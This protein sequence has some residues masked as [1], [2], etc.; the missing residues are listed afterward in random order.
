MELADLARLQRSFDQR[1][2][3]TFDWSGPVT[4]DD[5][6]PLMHNVLSLCGE[7]GEVANLLKK[8]DRG[9][10]SFEELMAELPS[11]LA[12]VAIYI[13]KI[14]YQSNIDLEKAI[15][16]KIAINE[17]RFPRS[18]TP[19]ATDQTPPSY[20]EQLVA[21]GTATADRLD[22]GASE[23]VLAMYGDVGV[24]PP[25]DL[26]AAVTGGLLAVEL[27]HAATYEG[28][29]DI[30]ERIWNSLEP[31]ARLVGLDRGAIS[32]LTHRESQFQAIFDE[33][34]VRDAGA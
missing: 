13:I 23:R 25:E 19:L 12:D 9:D 16:D 28:S 6:R 14:A 33:V 8:Y 17:E 26:W 15:V 10:F 1:R 7:A 2:S 30:R 11:E 24:E 4:K 18:V 31:V 3:T 27:A 22:G 29:A 32:A 34:N 21:K 5:L 20:Q